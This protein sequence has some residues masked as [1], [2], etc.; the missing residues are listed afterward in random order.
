MRPLL[1][2]ALI[3]FGP[4]PALSA[5]DFSW[6]RLL[7]GLAAAMWEP[8]GTCVEEGMAPMVVLKVDP[9][10]FRFAT[11]HFRQEGL[12]APPTILE[13]QEYTGAAV[14]LNAGQ[15]LADYSYLGL[16]FKDGRSIGGK[17][18]PSWHGLFVAE[19]LDHGL[20]QA[21]IL[22]LSIERFTEMQPAY[23]EAAQS[24]MLLDRRG[25]TRVRRSGRQAQQSIVAEYEDGSI[26][27]IKTT[28]ETALWELANCLKAGFSG[29]RQALV[30]DGGSS[31][32]LLVS[33]ETLARVPG[34]GAAAWRS[35]IDGHGQR[36]I[37]LP[38][39]IGVFPRN[40]PK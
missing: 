36:H 8:R 17:R 16:L 25:Q 11:F 29:I 39:V 21:G 19:P 22:D 30:L 7:E 37:A 12:A 20:K 4:T 18:H 38:S 23:R 34:S 3:A 27:L 9:A 31:S 28:E 35:Y 6:D 40:P 26:L 1:F 32:D 10:R 5:A 33:P 24:L 13:W 15:F 2:L 14:V